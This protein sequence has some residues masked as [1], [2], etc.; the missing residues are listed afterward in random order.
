MRKL[1]AALTLALL[2]ITRVRADDQPILLT[3]GSYVASVM[4][5]FILAGSH[6]A[7]PEL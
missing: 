7:N 4:T 1:T 2:M 3:D 6:S 5:P